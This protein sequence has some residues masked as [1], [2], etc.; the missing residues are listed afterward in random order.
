MRKLAL[1]LNS[2]RLFSWRGVEVSVLLDQ[3]VRVR[4]RAR[5]SETPIFGGSPERE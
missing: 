1:G 3:L 4:V 5:P 2:L